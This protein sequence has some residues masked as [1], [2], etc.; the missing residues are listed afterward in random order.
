[1]EYPNIVF[2]VNKNYI[3]YLMVALRSLG[4]Y[5]NYSINIYLLYSNLTLKSLNK[6]KQI[7]DDLNYN[8][9][10]IKINKDLF[11]GAKEM[12]H[13]KLEAYY[14]IIIPNLIKSKSVLYL[15]CD[16]FIKADIRELFKIDLTGY[17][18]AAVKDAIIYEPKERYKIKDKSTYFNTGV[19]LMNL[20]FWRNNYLSKIILDFSIVNHDLLI[21]ADQCAINSIID[22]DYIKLDRCYNFQ[23][24]HL[25]NNYDKNLNEI[26]K[27][28][29][30]HFTGSYKPTHYLNKH[31]FTEI[32]LDELKFIPGYNIFILK[33]K[34]SNFVSIIIELIKKYLIK[35]IKLII[36]IFSIID[37][38][39]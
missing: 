2:V 31:P 23:T 22:G 17:A 8:F 38:M 15:D 35:K 28:K 3:S 11:D 13:L 5:N 32:Y 6:I 24:L 25:T 29:I 1:M 36:K 20:D 37:V 16:I 4:K 33:N 30:I 34:I 39:V 26:E 21:Y 10:P 14:R 19:L 12:G 9:K 7:S 27:S 18:L